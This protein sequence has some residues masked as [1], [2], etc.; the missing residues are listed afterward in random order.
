M[1]NDK[2]VVI[3]L[4]AFIFMAVVYVK[5][6]KPEKMGAIPV[7]KA[8]GV[9]K[10]RPPVT[11]SEKE[12]CACSKCM[13]TGNKCEAVCDP[14]FKCVLDNASIFAEGIT[15]PSQCAEACG[16]R[17]LGFLQD[18]MPDMCGGAYKDAISREKGTVE[19]MAVHGG[20]IGA[21][22]RYPPNDMK[23]PLMMEADPVY[24]TTR[25]GWRPMETVRGAAGDYVTDGAFK[26]ESTLFHHQIQQRR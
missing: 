11:Q 4:A 21:D 16:T 26:F 17:N 24:Q 10:D 2:A 15:V 12:F 22:R 7:V 20:V 23:T 19:K 25:A 14:C 13:K 3:A 6:R 5:P 1:T 8:E 9:E 18:P